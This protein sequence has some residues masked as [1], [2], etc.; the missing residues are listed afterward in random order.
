MVSLRG[1][2]WDQCCL[3]SSSVTDIVMECTLSKFADDTKLSSA[4]DIPEGWDVIQ[5]DLD[6]LERWACENLMRF[7]KT[8]R[9]IL[10]WGQGNTWY[11]YRL[12]DEEIES[13]PAQ[14][15][16]GV[17]VNGK[18]GMSQQCALTAQKA[19]HILGCI[20]SSMAAV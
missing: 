4:V 17:L 11:Q 8:K 12:G 10:H 20:K 16:L 5:G 15:D 2:Y 18:L 19:N 14:K 9:K 13:S 6:K 7:N 1:L 3:I